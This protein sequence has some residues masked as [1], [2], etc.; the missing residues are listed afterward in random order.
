MKK[1]KY[2]VL[3]DKVASDTFSSY[4]EAKK[5]IQDLFIQGKRSLSMHKIELTT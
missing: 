5:H 1:W 4:K 3:C 2:E